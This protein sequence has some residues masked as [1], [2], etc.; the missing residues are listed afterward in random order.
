MPDI[1]DL[2]PIVQKIA[3]ILHKFPIVY[4]KENQ[5]IRVSAS[6]GVAFHKAGNGCDYE[7]IY[8]RADEYMYKAKK[9]GKGIAVMENLEG[10]DDIVIR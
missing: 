2:K 10:N 8:R 3:D 9:K 1:D 7:E 5:E 4:K 6:I